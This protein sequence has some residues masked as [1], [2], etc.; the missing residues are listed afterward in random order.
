VKA[1]RV[2][3]RSILS[4]KMHGVAELSAAP[5]LAAGAATYAINNTGQISLAGL[6]YALKGTKINLT[7]QAFDSEGQ[8]FNP[9]SMLIGDVPGDKLRNAL[10]IFD[11]T[12]VGLKSSPSVQ[13]HSAGTPRIAFM[14]TWLY[15]QTEGWWRM[16]FDKL[17]VP[18]GYISTQTVNKEPDL[19]SKY[20][21]I[22]FAPVGG[23]KSEK[24]INGMPLFGKP[25]P[26][27]KTELT[28]NLGVLDTTDDV[29]P[30]LGFSGVDHL[31]SFIE[32]GGLL[33][34]A[35]DTAEFAIEEGL[36]PGVSVSPKKNAKVVGSV[37]NAVFVDKT[38]PVSFGYGTDL[39]VY[40][41]DGLSF[42]VSD[43]TESG[44]QI[45]TAKEYKRVTGR[46]GPDEE[47]MPTGRPAQNAPLLPSPKTW[48]PTPLNEDQARNNLYLIPPAARP[49]VILRYG[50]ARHLLLSGLLENPDP[51]AEHAVVVDA[52]LGNGNVL[53][54]GNNPVYRGETIGSYALVFNAILHFNC[55]NKKP[56]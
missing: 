8:H 22:I 27:Q 29:R 7:E 4:V 37:L 50:D 44:R 3:E 46:G 26:W 51:I 53:L 14:H 47:D 9:G 34:A 54:F 17:H 30:G 19:S 15:T 23:V 52:R 42:N 38:N 16:A 6:A 36:A 35:E 20:D 48:E 32:K 33:V 43:T 55:L 1:A 45:V 2:T 10:G 28:P 49:S 5:A 21:V 56:H 25:I 39:P 41:E 11:L 13:M 31:K 40:S 18:Y 24:I 12:A